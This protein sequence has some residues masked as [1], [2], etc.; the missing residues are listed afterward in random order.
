MS[1]DIN[2]IRHSLAHLMAAA[3]LEIYPDA[4]NTIGPAVDNG[5][6]YDFEF[7]TPIS[8]KELGKIENKMRELV[9]KW[10][11]F[12]QKTIEANEALEMFKANPYKTELINELVKNGEKLSFYTSGNFTDLCAGPHVDSAKEIDMS[13]L[14]L[15]RIAGAYWRGDENNKMLT[16]IY[17][18][19]FANKAELEAYIL[20]QEEAKKRDHRKIGKELKL[21]TISELVGAGLP[22]LQ[23]NGM[24]MREAIEDYLWEL[25]KAKGCQ[26]VW[27]PH[28]TKKG[29]YHLV[30]GVNTSEYTLTNV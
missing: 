19:A 24:I 18:L 30:G 13:G 1:Q 8:D 7:S 15:E 29:L 23:P 12:E 26:R 9:K 16:R 2:K 25:N 20:Q 3:V 17:G 28:I 27:T 6:Y 5:F 10:D 11:K 14:K 21:F 22:L 4:K